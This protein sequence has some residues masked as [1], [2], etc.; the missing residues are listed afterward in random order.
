[1]MKKTVKHKYKVLLVAIVLMI[2]CVVYLNSGYNARKNEIVDYSACFNVTKSVDGGKTLFYGDER[3]AGVIFYPGGKVESAS[4]EP[5]MMSLADKGIVTVLVDMPFDLAVFDIN[6]AEGIADSFDDIDSWYMAGHS[7][8][9]AMAASFVAEN[10]NDFDG[11]ILLGAYS[12]ADLSSTD[13]RVL[14]IYGS[15][16]GVMN[17]EKYNECMPNIPEAEEVV[18]EGGNHAFF[19][20]YG[21]QKGDGKAEITNAEQIG[22]TAEAIAD[23]I[24][25]EE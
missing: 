16:D 25:R 7:L 20:M 11:L 18:I 10:S 2:V 6:A 24:Y 13:I 23:F 9:G 22:I 3:K 14:S 15:N 5:L 21:E 12:T 19:G 1:M 4:Y 17:R 8:G